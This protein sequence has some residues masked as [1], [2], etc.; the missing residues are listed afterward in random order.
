MSFYFSEFEWRIPPSPISYSPVV[1]TIWQFVATIN[2]AFGAWYLEWRWVHSLNFAALWFALPLV[3]SETLAYFGLILFTINLWKTSDYPCRA[4]PASAMD[5]GGEEDRPISIDVFIATY[6]EDEELV[7]LSIRDACRLDYPHAIDVR[8]HVLDDGSRPSMCVVA[9]EEGVNY[10]TRE[11]NV[12]FKAGNLRNAMEQ[13]S[14]DFMIICDADTRL[15]PNFLANTLGH[16]R[17]PD[18]AFVQTPHWFYDIPAGERLTTLL[19]RKLGRIAAGFGAGLERLV[20]EVRI[21]EDPF[22][23]DPRLFF[24]IIQRRR[25]WA[26]AAFCCGASSIHRREAVMFVALT[27]YAGSVGLEGNRRGIG[28]RSLPL[29]GRRPNALRQ[30]TQRWQAAQSKEVTPYKFHVSC[31]RPGAV[32]GS[33]CSIPMLNRGC[34]RRRIY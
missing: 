10:I 29:L 19:G 16:F 26:N 9:A 2:L 33:Q 21:G 23:N 24:D 18:V 1:E 27:A 17:N 13:T 4:G 32:A 25:N 11:N 6:N 14:G 20:G 15:F 7:R 12:G 22:V 8:I 28:F 30:A 31:I 3:L 34:C 5:C